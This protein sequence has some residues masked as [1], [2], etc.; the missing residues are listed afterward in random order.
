MS[1]QQINLCMW[2]Y[3]QSFRVHVESSMNAVI[4]ELGV[5]EAEAEC[6]LVG[7]R[8]PSR[9]NLNDV[10]VEPEEGKWPISLFDG[11]LEAIEAEFASHPERDTFYGDRPRMEEKPEKLVK[12]HW[13][14]D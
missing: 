3:Q 8:I 4:K 14:K 6:L 9:Q 11:L 13:V 10:C 7:V 5:P 2:G 1:G 12:R